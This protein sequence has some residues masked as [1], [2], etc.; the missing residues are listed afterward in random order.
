MNMLSDIS[1]APITQP[2]VGSAAD[3]EHLGDQI[4]ELAARLDAAGARLLDL[5]REFDARGG[6]NTGF[7]SCAAWL[8]WRGRRGRGA[9][10]PR[11][12]RA[13]GAACVSR[14]RRYGGHPRPAGLGGRRGVRAGTSR[15]PRDALSAGAR[16][17]RG[18]RAR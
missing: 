8:T 4:A 9:A 14:R 18:R 1:L 17:T 15:G 5:I 13:P 16:H 10:P 7:V 2:T 3:L 12:R 6:W 11:G